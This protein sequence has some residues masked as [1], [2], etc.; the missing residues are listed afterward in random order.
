MDLWRMYASQS[1]RALIVSLGDDVSR[2]R[3]LAH[4]HGLD[5]DET[6]H[7]IHDDP[8]VSSFLADEAVQAML[9]RT[10]QDRFQALDAYLAE[11]WDRDAGKLVVVDVGWRGTIQD[12][13][14]RAYPDLF[15]IGCYLALFPFLNPQPANVTKSAVGPDGNS[16]DDFA[17]MEP[18]AAVERP[19]TPDVPSVVDYRQDPNGR[20]VPVEEREFL[21][22]AER[23]LIDA[24]QSAALDAVR[25]VAAWIASEGLVTEDLRPLI[26]AEVSDYYR[27]PLPGCAD[28]WF[29]SAHDDTFGALNVTPFGK[30]LP[31]VEWLEAGL[32][33]G[34]RQHLER[35]AADSMWSAGYRAWLPVQSLI[36]LER[37]LR[38]GSFE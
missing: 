32:G 13:L 11:T 26:L 31:T 37:A 25:I 28:I 9:S 23:R 15:I 20:S 4:T 27:R 29:S 2:Y 3:R 18:P 16:G 14:A 19:W 5:I 8:R 35:A 12:N 36:S 38:T 10:N 24:F 7:R 17:F 22:H 1:L 21:G 33:Y 34:F 30:S 6:V